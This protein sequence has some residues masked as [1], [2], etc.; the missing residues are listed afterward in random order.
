[1]LSWEDRYSVGIE[2]IDA[3]HRQL[4]G[5]INTLGS[6]MLGGQGRAVLGKLVKELLAYTKRHFAD[7]ERLFLASAYPKDVADAHVAAHRRLS[8]EVADLE[9]RVAQRESGVS[10]EIF[11]FLKRWITEHIEAEDKRYAPFVDRSA[12]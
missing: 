10:V 3:Q 7:E 6:A 9:E 2:S 12:G 11:D 4:F 8:A 5:L 1:M